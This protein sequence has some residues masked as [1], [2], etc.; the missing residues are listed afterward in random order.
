MRGDAQHRIRREARIRRNAA[1]NWFLQNTADCGPGH[2]L[3]SEGRQFGLDLGGTRIIAEFSEDRQRT[4]ERLPSVIHL[5]GTELGL[6]EELQRQGLIRA[7]TGGAVNDQSPV[8]AVQGV[9]LPVEAEVHA[10]EVQQDVPLPV[11]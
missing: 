3:R 11:H 5:P 7:V 1:N 10:T 2:P 9:T 4:G 8:Q 6:P